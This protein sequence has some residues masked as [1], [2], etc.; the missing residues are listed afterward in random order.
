MNEGDLCMTG[1]RFK[2][3]LTSILS[4]NG[5]EEEAPSP[6]WG[7]GWDEGI[8]TYAKLLQ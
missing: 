8:H 4:S 7:E 5:G 2:I 3:L 1:K 6:R